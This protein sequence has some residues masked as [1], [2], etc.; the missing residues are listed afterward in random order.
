VSKKSLA[1][2]ALR[3]LRYLFTFPYIGGISTNIGFL[4]DNEKKSGENP[5][6]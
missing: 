6:Y 1:V 4:K 5:E 3:G 2:Q